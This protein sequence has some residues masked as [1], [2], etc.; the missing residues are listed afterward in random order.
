M[1]TDLYNEHMQTHVCDACA[2]SGLETHAKPLS[3]DDTVAGGLQRQQTE[4]LRP[5][6]HYG[7]EPVQKTTE[8][9]CRN[10]LSGA[11]IAVL[12]GQ[13]DHEMQCG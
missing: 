12:R 2:F 7:L 13:P 9:R 10:N 3:M 4:L 5:T 8:C 1:H 11:H 6:Q